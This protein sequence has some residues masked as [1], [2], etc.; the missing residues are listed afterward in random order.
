M[1]DLFFF[2]QYELDLWEF[3]LGQG[4]FF[5]CCCCCQCQSGQEFVVKIFSCRLEV[6][7]QCEVVVLC[8]CQLYFNVVNLYE[9]YYD[10]LYMY[11]VLELLWGGELLEYICKKWY[12][13]ELE[14]SQILCSFVLVVSFMYEE[15]GVVYC[16]FKLENILYVDDM[17]GVLVKII[18]FGFVWLWLQSF[19]V[20][21]QMFCFMLQ[22]VV[23]E[24]LVQQGY[25]EFC[26][27]WSLGVILGF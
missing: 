25:D 22:Y 13:S 17:F 4:S 16:D 7:M 20:F 9:V 11:L 12:F 2:Q 3:V 1:Q 24:L 15:V 14:V 23:F 19:G 10:Q 5:V 6:N 27:F 21:M 18:D 8:L 26:D